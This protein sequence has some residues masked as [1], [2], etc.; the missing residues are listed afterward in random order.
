MSVCII[1]FIV[2]KRLISTRS[3]YWTWSNSSIMSKRAKAWIIVAGIKMSK[4]YCRVHRNSDR[5]SPFRTLFWIFFVNVMLLATPRLIYLVTLES[6]TFNKRISTLI[7][8]SS[9]YWICHCSS[10][11]THLQA[12]PKICLFGV[13][14]LQLANR[15]VILVESQMIRWAHQRYYVPLV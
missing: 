9:V 6:T 7:S 1:I 5:K 14:K 10:Y 15:F 13:L 3:R 2:Q 8:K 11:S 4:Y 12:L